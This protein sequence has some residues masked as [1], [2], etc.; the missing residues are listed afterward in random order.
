MERLQGLSGFNINDVA[1]SVGSDP[2]VLRLEN[3][4]TDLRPPQSAIDATLAAVVQDDANSYLP[5]T[6]SL[7]LRVAIG[8]RLSAQTGQACSPDQVVVTCG[9]TEGMLDV[10]LAIIDPGDEV[11]VT[12]PTYAGMINRVRLAGGTPRFVPFVR[13]GGTW[14]LGVDALRLAIGHR[15]RAI[16]L[17]N[18][19]M[20]SGAWLDRTE[21]ETVETLCDRH[22]LWLIYNAAMERIL[23]QGR[24]YFHPGSLPGLAARTISVGSVSKEY[25]MI[26][27]RV[28][29]VAGPAE[30]MS[31]I[32]RVHIYNA[33]TPGGIGQAGALAALTCAD[34]GLAEC[35]R[36]WE[37]RHDFMVESLRGLPLIPAAGGWSL[38]LDC[39]AM[40]H[41][42]MTASKLLLA[43]GK[44]AA[45]PMR[46]WGAQV[47]DNMVRFVFS[48]EPLSRLI[49]IRDRVLAAL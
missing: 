38:L 40:G 15:T 43:R 47:A 17:M 49:G 48:N 2:D 13:D 35:V 7:A 33:V 5:F 46:G 32:G 25:R 6:G 26:G 16:F 36:E 28:G 3:L 14:R 24:S 29:W 42:C 21:W 10:L 45:T 19:S 34:D 20:P 4:D 11:I 39:A 37:K 23:F 30:V 12:D 1:D 9:G 8:H 27:W 18:P 22:H 41:D 31:D 44:I